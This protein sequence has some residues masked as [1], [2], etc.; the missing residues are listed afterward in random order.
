MLESGVSLPLRQI[1]SY[2]T[3]VGQALANSFLLRAGLVQ[4]RMFWDYFR[5]APFP[6]PLPE[7]QGDCS[8]IFTVR[9]CRDLGGKTHKSVGPSLSLGSLEFLT[10]RL[11]QTE[12]P[13]LVSDN[14]GFPAWALVPWRFSLLSFSCRKL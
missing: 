6:M 5:V 3:P 12:S 14:L 10:L 8:L 1:G 13:A 7:A 4:N 2:K 9:T 11:V